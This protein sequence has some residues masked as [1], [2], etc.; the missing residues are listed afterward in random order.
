M[1]DALVLFRNIIDFFCHKINQRIFGCFVDFQKAFD[2]IP[3]QKLF[4]KLKKHGITGKFFNSLKTMYTNDSCKIKIVDWLSEEI[5]PNQ[6]VRQG[7]V[8]SPLLFNIFMADLPQI[9]SNDEDSPPS[10]DGTNKLSCL[11]WADDL[12]LFSELELGLNSML[13][14]L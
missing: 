3:R 14:K 5:N 9:F 13:T 6:G 10:I 2:I 11:L 1:P 7:C 12:I 8:L 4:E